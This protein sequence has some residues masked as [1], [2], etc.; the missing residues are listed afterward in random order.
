MGYIKVGVGVGYAT[1]GFPG[2]HQDLLWAFPMAESR[3]QA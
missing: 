2:I 3:D 1:V